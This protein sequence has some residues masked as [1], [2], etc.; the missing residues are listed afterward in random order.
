MFQ[1]KCFLVNNWY[2]R[3]PERPRGR[4]VVWWYW[5]TDRCSALFLPRPLSCCVFP[6]MWPPTGVITA[7]EETLITPIRLF[8]VLIDS[9]CKWQRVINFPLDRHYQGNRASNKREFTAVTRFSGTF[10]YTLTPPTFPR[11]HSWSTS[12]DSTRTSQFLNV[13]IRVVL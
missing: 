13:W 4:F 6:S 1:K 9:Y 5:C 12:T 11:T 3:V 8:E 2:E 10:Y 7:L